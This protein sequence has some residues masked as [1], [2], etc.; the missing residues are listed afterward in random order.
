MSL[1]KSTLSIGEQLQANISYNLYYDITD[2]LGLGAIS[3]SIS[4]SGGGPPLL[5]KEYTELGVGVEKHV[6]IDIL[7]QDW[8]PNGEGQIGF[9]Q[10]LGWVQ[11]SYNSMTDQMNKTF[12][13]IRSE[14]SLQVENTPTD[15]VFHDL[16]NITAQLT[17]PHN[18]TLPL[19]NH[20]VH[21]S[22]TNSSQL[23]QSW[24]FT[25][26]DDGYI[27][28]IIDTTILGTGKFSYN[29]TSL[30]NDDYL[31]ASHLASFNIT[32]ANMQLIAKLNATAYQAY[33]PLMNNCTV[34]VT[35]DS[36]CYSKI[37]DMSEATVRWS[38]DDRNGE[39]S[40]QNGTRFT[41]EVITPSIPGIYNITITTTLVNHNTNSTCIPL[42]VEPRI[43][44]ILFE[45]NCSEAAYGDY[46]NF[47]LAVTDSGCSKPVG[48]KVV[49][50]FVLDQSN[51]EFVRQVLLD[52]EG[53]ASFCWQARD[54]GD[55]KFRLMALLEGQPEYAITNQTIEIDN[56]QTI[57]F[58]ID[59]IIEGVRGTQADC[60][61]QI[62]T[63]DN[64]PIPNLT[65]NLVEVGSDSTWC[66]TETNSS[67]YATLSWYIPDDY[68]LGMHQF[69]LVC[70]DSME[71]LGIITVTLIVYT[72]TLLHVYY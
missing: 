17:N 69:I 32:N 22:I 35:V 28:K 24:N 10:V 30:P 70:Q 49:A 42:I 38:L 15:I 5:V 54:T 44:V 29:I 9:I 61:L 25:T 60:T 53:F 4:A 71:I 21:I 12:W 3:I 33:F 36:L 19:A 40:Y 57:R 31:I 14:T 50:I 56:T 59:T 67:G 58:H 47:S 26:S 41:G 1:S 43:P 34:I 68:S 51:W 20:E 39:L 52:D 48:G 64:Y 27:T 18:N 37:H 65:L 13:V 63:L 45:A 2:P 55:D 7:P 11:D 8:E 6:V 66:T 72:S 62:T 23:V 46:I 16:L